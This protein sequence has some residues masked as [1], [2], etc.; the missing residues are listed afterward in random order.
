MASK[1][2][3]KEEF[4]LVQ[5]VDDLT[6]FVPNIE[7]AK[8]VF[9]LLDEF[10]SCSGLIV[11]YT[12]TE[13]TWIGSSRDSTAA[14]L[15]LTWRG[16]KALGIVFTYNTS[17][18]VQTNFYDKLKDIQTQTRLW[19]CRGKIS[20]I[21]SC[22]LPKMFYVFSVL[23]TPEVFIKQLNTIIYNFLWKGPDKI[24]VARLAVINDLKYGGLNLTELE[25][26]IKSLKISLARQTFCRRFYA[27]YITRDDPDMLANMAILASFMQIT[28][29]EM[30]LTCR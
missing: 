18:L 9:R 27:N 22:L 1:F 16:M 8:R 19:S 26:S 3:G 21:K 13:A 4:K 30:G 24:H 5:Y 15:G 28:S 17:V 20:I 2:I 25:T 6:V 10:R 7:C 29:P 23:P 11:N 12:K 14:P